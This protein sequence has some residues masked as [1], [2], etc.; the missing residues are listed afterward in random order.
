MRKDRDEEIARIWEAP[1]PPEEFARRL[2]LA[3]AELDGP[4]GENIQSLITW[5]NRRYPTPL[6]RLR[7]A[8]RKR[9]GS[10]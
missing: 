9:L 7:Y 10:E 3:R 2:A 4:E 6:D 5:F 1:L 8:R